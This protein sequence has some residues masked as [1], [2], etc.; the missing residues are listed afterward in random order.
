MTEHR[1]KM[2]ATS[3]ASSIIEDTPLAESQA[4]LTRRVLRAEVVRNPHD[5]DKSVKFAIVHQRRSS[6]SSAWEDLGGKQLSELRGGEAMKMV[7][8]TNQTH[9]LLQHLLNLYGIGKGGVRQGTTVLEIADEEE[10]IKT[11]AG[12]AKL[13]RKLLEKD[14]QQEVWEALTEEAPDL[15]TKMSLARIYEQR[16]EV[17]EKFRQHIGGTDTEDKWQAFLHKE[18]WI[19][20]TSYIGRIGERRINI[21]SELDHPLIT[22]DGYLEIVEIK[23]PKFDFWKKKRD[24]TIMLYRDKYP[25]VDDELRNAIAQ[26]TNY[27][28]EAEAEIDSKIWD[29]THDGIPPLKPKCLVVH[30]RS[31]EWGDVE[32]RAFRLLNDSLHGVSV[33]TFD[34]LLIRAEQLVEVFKPE[35][36]L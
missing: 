33:I 11:D 20:G 28:A 34:H 16:K 12:R 15:V 24:G 7:F 4:G 6:S 32:K 9:D 27:V 30:G 21:K 17:I 1:Y 23:R 31:N 8:D 10:V 19:F 36:T 22:E 5:G 2:T 35:Q 3:R 25:V 26:G 13:I 14:Y 29:E 18:R